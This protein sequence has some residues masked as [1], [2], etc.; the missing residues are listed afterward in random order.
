MRAQ[1]PVVKEACAEL[2]QENL[3]E[4]TVPDS[5]DIAKRSELLSFF[6]LVTPLALLACS[7]SAKVSVLWRS[8]S[9]NC[10]H[11]IPFD[12]LCMQ[13]AFAVCIEARSRFATPA[14]QILAE[15]AA[16]CGAHVRESHF[17]PHAPYL[18]ARRA[19][20]HA[21]TALEFSF[22]ELTYCWFAQQINLYKELPSGSH[23]CKACRQMGSHKSHWIWHL[24]AA[25]G[26]QSV[27]GWT[28]IETLQYVVL[29]GWTRRHCW[30]CCRRT[31]SPSSPKCRSAASYIC[32]CIKS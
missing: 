1:L 8:P 7:G 10:M 15:G 13:I 30:N 32:S 16:E 5:L 4:Q 24:T 25:A 14:A 21:W 26:L 27:R 29:Q 12:R 3:S 9:E 31:T 20:H 22:A 28:A 17:F 2:I 18:P 6:L 23:V 11:R 19:L